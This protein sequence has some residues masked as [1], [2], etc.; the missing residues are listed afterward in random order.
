MFSTR[1]GDASAAVIS[2]WRDGEWAELLSTGSGLETA[3]R[4]AA[5]NQ[6]VDGFALALHLHPRATT[7]GAGR[8]ATVVAAAGSMHQRLGRTLQYVRTTLADAGVEH[9]ITK[10]WR[11]DTYVTRDVDVLV[12]AIDWDAASRALAS[13]GATDLGHRG[14]SGAHQTNWLREGLLKIDLHAEFT[15][16]NYQHGSFDEL[17]GLPVSRELAGQQIKTPPAAMELALMAGHVLHERGFLT[18]LDVMTWHELASNDDVHAAR[19]IASRGGWRRDFDWF[20]AWL[21][22]IGPA[23]WSSQ[24]ARSA[25]QIDGVWPALVPLGKVLEVLGRGIVAG[26]RP[27]FFETLYVPY[28]HVVAR[29]S[30]RRRLP[31]FSAWLPKHAS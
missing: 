21:N 1:T 31:Y 24:D 6:V 7:G 3:L 23:V 8:L 19:K 25:A 14:K 20:V 16:L 10:T 22:R 17:W 30:R 27:R 29:V 13:G 9:R 28:A 11:P 5:N 26:P 15:W 18:L 12:A 2:G 4:C